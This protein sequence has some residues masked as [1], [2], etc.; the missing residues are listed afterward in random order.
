MECFCFHFS[1]FFLA[2]LFIFKVLYIRARKYSQLHTSVMNEHERK[3]RTTSRLQHTHNK[4]WRFAT[5][6]PWTLWHTGGS[7]QGHP[8]YTGAQTGKA[9]GGPQQPPRRRLQTNDH[10]TQTSV[11]TNV[12][13][14]NKCRPTLVI[15]H[16]SGADSRNQ[17]SMETQ[18]PRMSRSGDVP[19]HPGE[20][21]PRDRVQQDS[22]E[23]V[24]RQSC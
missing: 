5:E 1:T 24:H 8:R 23:S 7:R 22:P 16:G 18:T 4:G 10:K 3:A 19:D 20:N 12:L 11:K 13:S 9:V 21:Q 2:F 6:S 15:L 17:R 14:G